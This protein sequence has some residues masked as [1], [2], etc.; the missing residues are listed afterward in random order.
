MSIRL[1]QISWNLACGI[2]VF[3]GG[4]HVPTQS[5]QKQIEDEDD[6]IPGHPPGLPL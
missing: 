2:V 6:E 3:R 4:Y 1:L 5:E